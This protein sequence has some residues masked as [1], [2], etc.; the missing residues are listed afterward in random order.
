MTPARAKRRDEKDFGFGDYLS[1]FTWR[2]ATPEMRGLFS[3]KSKRSNWRKVWLALAEVQNQLG[4]VTKDDLDA[5]RSKSGAENVDI[6][7]A[8]E[9]E[10]E[11]RHD[12]MAEL[13]TF[14]GQAGP[15]GGRLHL[16]A[17]SMDIEDNADVLTFD[18]AL[19]I[20]EARLVAC[21]RVAKEKVVRHRELVCMAW[22]HLQPAEPTTLGYR[23]ASYAQDLLVDL[24]LVRTLR[25]EY[26][27]GK[28]IKGAV[29]TSASF[30]ALLGSESRVRA[31]E[32]S[33]MKTLGIR[34]FEVAT[35]TYPR[36]LDFLIVT[37]LAS[38]AQSCHKFGLDL[39]VLQSPAF[40][41]LSE[42]IGERQVG[43]S[44]MPFKRNPVLAERMCSLARFV[45]VLPGVA[46]SNA[47]N[48]VLE[49][50]LD[51]S[52]S[53][54]IVLPEAFMAIDECLVIYESVLRG[55]V[56]YTA[57][58]QKNLERYGP[59]AGTEGVLMK[60]T[61]LGGDRQ[62]LHELIRVKSFQAWKEVMEGKPNPMEKLLASDKVI[63]SKLS[64]S[65]IH[66]LMDPAKHTGDASKRC[67][68]FLKRELDPMLA[69]YG[70]KGKRRGPPTRPTSFH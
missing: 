53:R 55:L 23:F 67:N 3:E 39:R 29:G 63:A 51:D 28:G 1:P 38:I 41:E 13:N 57:M 10:K 60:L 40:G 4:L 58:I 21:L 2:Y 8:H 34:P 24:K 46:F 35:Q 43:S 31:Q 70:P 64:P 22:T 16:G 50:T 27:R 5:I 44:A 61:E 15:G 59:F 48:S 69:G 47:A 17:T 14:A 56:I 18:K 32:E 33:V 30:M 54:R 6:A 62:K 65:A 42:P 12:L 52:A 68:E 66:A 9:L 7:R 26:L 20:V 11:I 37:C 49:R 36:K 19:S 45:S 25:T